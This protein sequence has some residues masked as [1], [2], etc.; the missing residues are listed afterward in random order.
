[1]A[2]EVVR[3]LVKRVVSVI[4]FVIIAGLLY[5]GLF[6][7]PKAVGSSVEPP[8]IGSR[9]LFYGVA[10]PTAAVIWGVGSYGKVVRSDDGGMTWVLQP[11]PREVC[12]QGIAAWN[13]R[14]A[15]IVGDKGAV[16]VTR[17]GGKS[18][19]DVKVP[20][21]QT[22]NKLL[23]VRAFPDGSGWAVGEMGA[24]IHSKDFGST[25]DRVLP[26]T[27]V[28]YNDICFVG[29]HGWLVGE[30]GRLMGTDDGGK[31]WGKLTSPVATSLLSVDFKDDRYGVAVGLE[32]VVIVTKDGGKHWEEMPK[33]MVEHL[34]NVIWDGATWCAVGDKGVFLK[35]NPFESVWKR[36]RLSENDISWHTQIIRMGNRYY[37]AGVTL[38]MLE[39]G[40]WKIFGK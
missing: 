25:W 28:A 6:I 38:G 40:K 27:D 3:R 34:F 24:V 1:M 33:V 31:T 10:A 30:F 8:V 19:Q 29:R 21:S 26:E 36:S 17:D 15:V 32:G 9:D 35:G 37:A 16:M 39:G 22:D 11:V 13:D 7:K 2:K 12:L 18:W 5:A 14:Q 23:R 4:P 20:L